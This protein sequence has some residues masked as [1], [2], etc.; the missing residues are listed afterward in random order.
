M[1]RGGK[2]RRLRRRSLAE[3]TLSARTV[4]EEPRGREG[5]RRAWPPTDVMLSSLFLSAGARVSVLLNGVIKGINLRGAIM[6]YLLVTTT[7][8]L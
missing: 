4:K 2:R 5:V 8:L 6:A 1:M 7:I 3:G